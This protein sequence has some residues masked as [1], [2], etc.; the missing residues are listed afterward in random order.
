M[1][2]YYIMIVFKNLFVKGNIYMIVFK[3][4]FVKGNIY[5]IVFK[6]LFVKGNLYSIKT[7]TNDYMYHFPTIS[8]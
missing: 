4:L 5:M 1:N 6:N 8:N 2:I 7:S 3:N